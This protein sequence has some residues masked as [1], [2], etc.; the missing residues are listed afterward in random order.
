MNIHFLFQQAKTTHNSSKC[1]FSL[2]LLLLIIFNSTNSLAAFSLNTNDPDHQILE[3]FIEK[4]KVPADQT[5]PQEGVVTDE[6]NKPIAGVTVKSA[7]H[8]ELVSITDQNGKFI[9]RLVDADDRLIF[10]FIGYEETELAVVKSREMNVKLK[11][12]SGTLDEIFVNGYLAKEKQ[13]ITGSVVQLKAGELMDRSLTSFSQNLQGRLT[14]VLSSGSTGQPGALQ[15][16]RIR[17]NGS[18]TAGADPLFVINGIPVG[19]GQLS[20]TVGTSDI[21]STIDPDDIESINILKDAS[22]SAIYGSRA[23]NGVI[24]ISTKKGSNRPANVQVDAAYGISSPGKTPLAGRPLTTDE[25]RRITAQGILNNASFSQQNN[26]DSKNVLNYVDQTLGAGSG[27]STDWLDLVSRVGVQQKYHAAVDGGNQN[28][29]YRLSSGYLEQDGTTISSDFKRYS[30]NADLTSLIGKRF[31]VSGSVILGGTGQNT[32]D[33]TLSGANPV[34]QAIH[35]LPFISPYNAD[36]SLNISPGSFEANGLFN[37]LY[38]AQNDKSHLSQLKGVGALTLGYQISPFL[39]FTSR[40]GLDYNTLEEDYY[41][42]PT[43]GN[44]IYYGGLSTRNYSRYHTWTWTNMLDYSLNLDK[45]AFWKVNL[46]GGYEAQKTAMYYISLSTT[47]LPGNSSLSVPSNGSAVFAYSAS[48]EDYTIASLFTMGDISYKEKFILS[49]SLRRDGSSKFSEKNRYGNF[50]SLGGAWNI[51]NE[52]FAKKLDW[53]SE[54]KLRT[55]YGLTGNANIGSYAWRQ[56]YSYGSSTLSNESLNYNGGNGTGLTSVGNPSLSWE[57][58]RQFDIGTDISIFDHRVA[59]SADYYSRISENLLLDQPISATSGASSFINNIGSMRNYGLEFAL[60]VIPIK[61]A[62][63]KWQQGFSISKNTNKIRSLVDNKDIVSGSYIRRV[64]MDMNTFYLRQWA[65]VDP[66][67][68]NPLWYTDGSMSSTTSNYNLSSPVARYSATPKL[69]G[70][71]TSTFSYKGFSLDGLLYYNF[72]N[73]VQDLWAR[74]TQSDGAYT[75]LNHY[76][77]QLNA[78]QKPG[79]ITNTPIYVFNNA[80]NSPRVSSRFVY[81]GDFIKLRE[82]TLAYDFPKPTLANFKLTA[83]KAFARATNLFTWVRDKD[84]PFDPEAGLTAQSNYNVPMPRMI[85]FGINA[86]F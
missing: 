13:Y 28:T 74:Y 81:K 2:V 68:G 85:I 9:I 11:K 6:D 73:Y 39:K 64:G 45:T 56:L 47:G 40:V 49:G 41:N 65:G 86:Q 37:P 79:D 54:M 32:V 7:K 53:L 27:V 58:N 72:G 29:Q 60:T 57:T 66:A 80:N 59:L 22:A 1:N 42:N 14:G 76:A 31:S 5:F 52:A 18:I 75:S 35:I 3:L 20:R 63:F 34:S 83:L 23:A 69:F 33:N 21:L 12:T 84:L 44:G 26:L 50:W 17:G 46:K 25:W 61:T 36:G 55:S 24:V 82:L 8:P 78:W 16:I 71:L 38:V 77:S 62:D 43:H 67:N 70:S 51:Q 15:E 4:L 10:S 30:L 48:N 19:G